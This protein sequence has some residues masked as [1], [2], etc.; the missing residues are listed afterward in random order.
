MLWL[1]HHRLYSDIAR[2]NVYSCHLIC[3]WGTI[4]FTQNSCRLDLLKITYQQATFLTNVRIT[5]TLIAQLFTSFKELVYKLIWFS[6]HLGRSIS[7]TI[8]WHYSSPT[9]SAEAAL[10]NGV[11]AYPHRCTR[12]LN[13]SNI[14]SID[15]DATVI[16]RAV[17]LAEQ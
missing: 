17:Y 11:P 10:P 2:T 5:I 12:S 8:P 3:L 14:T 4:L 9:N 15:Y 16:T 1:C 7:S 13:P 6:T